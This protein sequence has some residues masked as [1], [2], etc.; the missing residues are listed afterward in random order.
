MPRAT[1]AALMAAV[2]LSGCTQ[3]HWY[4]D[5]ASYEQKERQALSCE[6][7]S[8][9]AL[10]PNVQRSGESTQTTGSTNCE[11]GVKH[12]CGKKN[13]VYTETTYDTR[14]VNSDGRDVLMK[15]CMYQKGWRQIEI[16]R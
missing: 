2:L 16:N 12:S 15:D 13:K 4:K 11:A 7:E 8:L 3:Y 9:R 5:G 14:D 10:P 6:A 1:C